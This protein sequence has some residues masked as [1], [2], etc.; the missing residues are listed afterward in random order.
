MIIEKNRVA[1]KVGM[2]VSIRQELP[3]G[4]EALAVM[5]IFNWDEITEEERNSYIEDLKRELSIKIQKHI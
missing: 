2:E 3:N 5:H 4:E 1:N